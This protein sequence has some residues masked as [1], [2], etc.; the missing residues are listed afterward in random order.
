MIHEVSGDILLTKAQ[1]IAHGV[2]PN[3]DFKQGL[4]HVLHEQWPAMVKDF[5]HWCHQSNPKPGGAWIW[6]GPD[7]HR[8]INLLT[9]E[10]PKSAGQH[11]GPAHLNYVNHALKDLHKILKKEKIASLAMP[12]IATGVGNLDWND[13]LPL[14]EKHL[15]PLSI[16]IIIYSEYHAGVQAK[17]PAIE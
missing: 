16:P 17:E 6:G 1:A 15:A 4:A 9:Q 5:R 12:K 13:V 10:P 11:P 8:I 14:I 7:G 2:A 3:D